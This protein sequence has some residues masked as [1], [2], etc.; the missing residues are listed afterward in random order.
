MSKDIKFEN[1]TQDRH[2]LLNSFLIAWIG[3]QND[4]AEQKVKNMIKALRYWEYKIYVKHHYLEYIVL[5]TKE[6]RVGNLFYI[7]LLILSLP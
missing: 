4:F 3:S 2:N 7:I 1:R 5:D 6:T